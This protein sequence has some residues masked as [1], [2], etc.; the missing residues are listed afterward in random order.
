MHK[1]FYFVVCLIVLGS[2][3]NAQ[4]RKASDYF[5]LEVGNI[6]EYKPNPD[7][8]D[9][10]RFE[11]VSDSLVDD[12]L[13]VYRVMAKSLD[14]PSVPVDYGYYHY[15]KDSMIVYR[16]FESPF[17]PYEG[18]PMIDTRGGPGSVWTYPIGDYL[19]AF[20]ITDTGKAFYLEGSRNWAQVQSG[21]FSQDDSV[22]FDQNYY[23]VFFEGIGPTKDGTDTLV[24]LRQISFF[25]L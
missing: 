14:N 5:P 6:W 17:V 13:R 12:T 10:R 25:V 3:A 21:F 24:L 8:Y 22:V 16:N 11:I 19:G 2:G 23:W 9:D 15:N 7:F 4:L 20:A 18:L 1:A